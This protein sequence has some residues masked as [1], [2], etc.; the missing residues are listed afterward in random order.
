MLAAVSVRVSIPGQNIMIKNQVRKERIYSSLYFQTAVHH[1][2]KS[3]LELRQVRKQE[4]MQRPWRDATYWLASPGLLSLLSYRTQVYQPRD[5]RWSH[6]QG[7]FPPWSLIEKMPYSWISWRHLPNWSSFLCD[8]SSL[9][10]VDTQNQ[11][12]NS[13]IFKMYVPPLTSIF[14]HASLLSQTWNK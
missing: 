3:G 12:V 5:G 4:L 2:R 8:N 13:G 6:P 14:P 11:P 1:Y 9:C 10:E 7:A